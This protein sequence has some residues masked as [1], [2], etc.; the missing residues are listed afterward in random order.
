MSSPPLGD[1][2]LPFVHRWRGWVSLGVA[3]SP[4][5]RLELEELEPALAAVLGPR[6]RRL[7]YL[8]EFFRCAGHQ[9]RALG[10]FVE[11]TEALRQALPDRLTEL[12][13]LT[14]AGALGNDYERNQ[15]ERLARRLGMS[16]GWVAAVHER[17]PARAA[18]LTED[19]RVVQRLVLALIETKGHGIEAEVEAVRA[20]LG[21]AATVAVLLLAG[22]YVAHALFVNALGIAPPVPSIFEDGFEP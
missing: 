14:A 8:G 16:R 22:R 4:I 18:E 3:M 21:D 11:F 2:A 17:D 19:E 5:P 1:R 6:V 10:A 20:R 15:H 13:A 12:V 9:P 7:G